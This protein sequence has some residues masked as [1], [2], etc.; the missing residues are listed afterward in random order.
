MNANELVEIIEEAGYETRRYSGRYMYGKECPAFVVE[1]DQDYKAIA[2]IMYSYMATYEIPISE[3][4]SRLPN[5][6]E[7]EKFVQILGRA[8]TDAM[9]RDDIIMYFPTMKFEEDNEQN[10]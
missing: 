4:D 1:S 3:D 10:S 2:E 6:D 9:G 8:K 5:I 7:L